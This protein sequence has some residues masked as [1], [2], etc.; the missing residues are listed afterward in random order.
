MRAFI[1]DLR[2]GL[3]M[4]VKSPVFTA[5]AVLSLAL[6]IGANPAIFTLLDAVLLRQLPVDNPQQL[7]FIQF[8]D[9]GFKP[10]SNISLASYEQLRT[11]EGI[12]NACFFSYTTKVNVSLGDSSEVVEGQLVSA[13][14]FDTLGVMAVVGRTITDSDD[15]ASAPNAAVISNQ[16]WQRR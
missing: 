15:S 1:Q 14:F 4:L 2:F 3:H 7:H 12:E 10:S 9:A 5:M 13:S 8:G 16:Y 6:G 11:Q